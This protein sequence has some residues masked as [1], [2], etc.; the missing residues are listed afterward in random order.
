MYLDNKDYIDAINA[1][2][3]AHHYKLNNPVSFCSDKLYIPIIINHKNRDNASLLYEEFKKVGLFIESAEFHKKTKFNKK[4]WVLIS[5]SKYSMFF[6]YLFVAYSPSNK[7]IL[8]NGILKGCT[9]L[10]SY[11]SVKASKDSWSSGLKIKTDNFRYAGIELG[12]Y[13]VKYC[14]FCGEKI[15]GGED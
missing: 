13:D 8:E 6:E 11:L 5:V 1:F 4:P 3:D 9:K 2:I 7:C 14:P 15:T 12:I 10:K